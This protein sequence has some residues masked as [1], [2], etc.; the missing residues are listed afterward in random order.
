M[1]NNCWVDKFSRVDAWVLVALFCVASVLIPAA[2]QC[3][4][5]ASI[6]GVVTWDGD[7]IAVDPLPVTKNPE[8]CGQESK[9]SPRLIVDGA[10]KAVK[11]VVVWL[12]DIPAGFPTKPDSPLLNQKNCEYEPHIIIVPRRQS[13]RMKSSDD[14]LHNIHAVGAMRFNKPFPLQNVEIKERARKAGVTELNCDAGHTWMSAFIFTTEHPYYA[15]TGD[16]GRFELKDVPAGE[17]TLVVWHE[18]WTITE[19]D[20]EPD[21]AVKQYH[22]DEPKVLKVKV[23][24][25]GSVARNFGLNAEGLSEK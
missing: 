16:D 19:V 23:N 11:N 9:V 18:G 4:G 17:H 7:V 6:T 24:V 10:S 2:G 22:F 21:G 14:I 5:A 3:E 8:V 20:K 15:V 1:K 25:E 13:L 12:E